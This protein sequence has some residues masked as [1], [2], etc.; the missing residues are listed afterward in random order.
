MP[1]NKEVLK[2]FISEALQDI[3]LEKKKKERKKVGRPRSK[4]VPDVIIQADAAHS[5]EQNAKDAGVSLSHYYK[6]ARGEVPGLPLDTAEK[7][8]RTTG[9]SLTQL[10][11]TID[12]E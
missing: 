7:I 11:D 6:A 4:E 10:A 12:G 2:K 3:L 5:A 1:T 8:R 9:V